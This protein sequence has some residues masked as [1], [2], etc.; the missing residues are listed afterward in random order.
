M[1]FL[2]FALPA[3]LIG[4]CSEAGP[5]S[6]AFDPEA[7]AKKQAA[8]E[9]A[10]D[11][12]AVRAGFAPEQPAPIDTAR[13]DPLPIATPGSALPP[14]TDAYRYI[15]R[16][17]ATPVLCRDGAWRFETRKLSTAGETS[18]KFD[19]VAAVPTG[20]ELPGVCEAEGAK[21]QQTLKLDFDEKRKIM[22]VE[23]K[24]LG[25]VDLIYCGA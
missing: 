14:A 1:R 3:L 12:R 11:Q 6:N 19:T 13:I 17:A 16:W 7:A 10:A 20:Y 4:A 5:I 8:R 21:T 15:G 9:Q 23:G 2:S 18:C 24:T 22:R 25:P